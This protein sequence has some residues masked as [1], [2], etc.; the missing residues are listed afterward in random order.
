MKVQTFNS[1][2]S[3]YAKP[4]LTGPGT[5]NFKIAVR[6]PAPPGRGVH[7]TSGHFPVAARAGVARY[8]ISGIQFIDS[9]ALLT[10][11]RRFLLFSRHGGLPT[12]HHMIFHDSGYI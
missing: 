6:I 10:M 12:L 2:T 4:V 1:P 9:L 5:S 11:R 8:Y 3:D 7:E